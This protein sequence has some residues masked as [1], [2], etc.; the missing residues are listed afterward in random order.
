VHAK[1][2]HNASANASIIESRQVRALAYVKVRGIVRLKGQRE[3][4]LKIRHKVPF[5]VT[6]GVCLKA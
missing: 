5:K 2:L 4:L 1:A 3:V 6:F